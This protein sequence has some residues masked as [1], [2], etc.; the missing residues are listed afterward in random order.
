MMTL[1]AG[2]EGAGVTSGAGVG[3]GAFSVMGSAR[4]GTVFRALRQVRP[5]IVKSRVLLSSQMPP[6]A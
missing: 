1:S 3:V 6:L 5:R 4:T 2:F